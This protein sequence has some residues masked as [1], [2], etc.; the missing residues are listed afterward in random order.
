MIRL[1]KAT[2]KDL[3]LELLLETVDWFSKQGSNQ[4]QE[5]TKLQEQQD[6][7]TM[8]EQEKVFFFYN[9]EKLAGLF[10]ANTKPSSWDRQLWQE[11]AAEPAIYIHKVII[12][13]KFRGQN[14]GKKLLNN[15]K[16]H[17]SGKT[18]LLRLDCLAENQGLNAFYNEN[19]YVSIRKV[20]NNEIGF[21][22]LYQQFID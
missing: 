14:L 11:K 15:I 17:F 5:L 6:F 18:N 1:V 19:D 3:A 7:L 20:K 12:R 13:P 21:F 8:V 4:W 22:E 16:D 10:I 9:K 2:E